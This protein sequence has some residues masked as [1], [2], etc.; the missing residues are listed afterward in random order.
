MRYNFEKLNFLAVQNLGEAYDVCS[1]MHYGPTAF[2]IVSTVLFSMWESH[3]ESSEVKSEKLTS[4][5]RKKIYPS[6]E[7]GCARMIRTIHAIHSNCIIYFK[8]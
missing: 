2:A 6:Q 1:V 5:L 4:S 3:G 8:V 7:G